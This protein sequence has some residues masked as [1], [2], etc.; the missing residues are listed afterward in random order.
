L[1]FFLRFNPCF[2]RFGAGIL[3]IPPDAFSLYGFTGIMKTT[4]TILLLCLCIPARPQLVITGFE[5]VLEMGKKQNRDLLIAA[6]KNT[7]DALSQKA[8]LAPLLPQVKS[9]TALDYNF[10]LPTQLIPAQ[11]LGGKEGEYQKIQFG[12]TYN[13]TTGV[14]AAMPLINPSAWTEMHIARLTRQ[15]GG[16]NNK[17]VAHE[18]EKNLARAYYYSLVSFKAMEISARNL[19]ANDSIYQSARN[20][21]EAG[22]ME[23]LDFNRLYNLFIQVQA[24]Y[25]QN[26][27]A[28]KKNLLGLKYM[29]GVDTSVTVEFNANLTVPTGTIASITQTNF[30]LLQYKEL[31]LMQS[32]LYLKKDKLKYAPEVSLFVR[33]QTQAQRNEFDFFDTDKSWFN[34]GVAGLRIDWPLFTGF[35]RNT[36]IKRSQQRVKIAELELENERLKTANDNAE[37]MMNYRTAQTVFASNVSALELA[38]QNITIAMEKYAQ[39]VFG[40]DQYLNIYNE[41]LQMQNNYVRALSELLTWQ[42]IV[43]LKNKQ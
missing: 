29:L 24:Q 43:E 1:V 18:I 3:V 27:L 6:E 37:T 12:T 34:I 7:V 36:T 42:T 38:T 4:V 35:A 26:K 8:A 31:A 23:Q 41:S 9:I 14:E 30:Y 13:L 40:I 2:Y 17:N 21:Y 22:V 33:Y 25:E 19:A 39:G 11:F 28:Y 32:K 20:K 15:M 16:L 5:Q 10:A